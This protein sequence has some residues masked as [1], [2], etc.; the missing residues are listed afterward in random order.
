M[1]VDAIV[2]LSVFNA[3]LLAA[4]L[5]VT[6]LSGRPTAWLWRVV[7][8]LSAASIRT[9]VSHLYAGIAVISGRAF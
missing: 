1:G 5:A 7:V 4:A 3:L 2:L 6:T 8:F 9:R